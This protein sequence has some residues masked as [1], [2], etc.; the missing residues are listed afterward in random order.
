MERRPTYV[1]MEALRLAI[2]AGAV[3]V[4]GSWFGDVPLSWPAQTAIGTVA[5]V[6][7]V[8]LWPIFKPLLCADG[9]LSHQ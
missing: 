5:A 1:W 2:T 4:H 3:L 8:S 9:Y 6:S 7:L